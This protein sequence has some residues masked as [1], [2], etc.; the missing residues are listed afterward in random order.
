MPAVIEKNA[1]CV[2]LGSSPIRSGSNLLEKGPQ[3]L[4][5]LFFVGKDF[6]EQPG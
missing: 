2:R 6:L 4:G 5:V 1:I 3:S